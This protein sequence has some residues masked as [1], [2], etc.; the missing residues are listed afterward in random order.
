MVILLYH[1]PSATSNS[2]PRM[3]RLR[4]QPH[5][6][7]YMVVEDLN[8]GTH[9]C[10]TAFLRAEPSFQ[11]P[12]EDCIKWFVFILVLGGERFAFKYIFVP[13]LCSAY[14]GQKRPLRSPVTE[15]TDSCE[16]PNG[17]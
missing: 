14:K 11:A 12:T 15:V 16:P 1:S 3:L 5:Q 4:V 9:A 17:C 6:I 2:A 13:C 7:F 8:S 10:T